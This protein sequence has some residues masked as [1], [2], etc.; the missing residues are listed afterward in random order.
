MKR[1]TSDR[2]R[3]LDSDTGRQWADRW[4]SELNLRPNGAHA[5]LV[6]KHNDL[7]RRQLHFIDSQLKRDNVVVTKQSIVDEAQLAHNCLISVENETPYKAV[8]GRTPNLIADLEPASAA[9][10]AQHLWHPL[11]S[12]LH[13]FDWIVHCSLGQDLQQYYRICKLATR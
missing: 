6:E 12:P 10:C 11:C 8:F 13:L 5:T 3:G 4:G 1:L 2:E 9:D 7:I